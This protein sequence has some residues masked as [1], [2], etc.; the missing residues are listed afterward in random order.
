M[1]KSAKKGTTGAVL[2]VPRT[3]YYA[4]DVVD[5]RPLS[6]TLTTLPSHPSEEKS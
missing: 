6:Y 3:F 1:A 2:V 4:L 5:E